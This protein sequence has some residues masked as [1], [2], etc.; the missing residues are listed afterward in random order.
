VPVIAVTLG[1]IPLAFWI[2]SSL[3]RN[4]IDIKPRKQMMDELE[5]TSARNLRNSVLFIVAGWSLR[6]TYR[7]EIFRSTT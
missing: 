2:G 6:N 5:I 1:T 4:S 3:M 7:L